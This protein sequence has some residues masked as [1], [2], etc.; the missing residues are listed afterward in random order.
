MVALA[1]G[2][3]CFW[4][5]CW[6]WWGWCVLVVGAVVLVLRVAGSVADVAAGGATTRASHLRDRPGGIAGCVK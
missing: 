4:W 2:G 5:G 3:A 1:S 6:Q